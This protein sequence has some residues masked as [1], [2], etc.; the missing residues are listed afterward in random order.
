MHY[1]NSFMR[2]LLEDGYP[3]LAIDVGFAFSKIDLVV[4]VHFANLDGYLEYALDAIISRAN[5]TEH[6]SRP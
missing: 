6:V 1:T 2:R 4:Y 5:Q 3:L